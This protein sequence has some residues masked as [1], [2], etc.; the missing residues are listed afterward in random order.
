M[1]VMD[2]EYLRGIGPLI[3]ATAQDY[4]EQ[5]QLVFVMDVEYLRGIGLMSKQQ[6]QE[7]P[8][9]DS[10]GVRDGPGVPQGHRAYDQSSGSAYPKQFQLVFEK[11]LEY[12]RSIGLMI[13]AAGLVYLEQI[14]LVFEKDLEYLRGIGLAI[15]AVGL[16]YPE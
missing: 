2:L 14:Q 11:D 8:E 7:Y 13:R 3:R 12:L 4:Q 16:V 5:I 10:A 9:A 15:K 1:F 6:A